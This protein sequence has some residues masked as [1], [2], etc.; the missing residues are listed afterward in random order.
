MGVV[1]GDITEVTFAHPLL[2]SGVFS[3]K[4]GETNTFDLG[5]FRN[6]DDAQGITGN[7]TLIIKKTRTRAS[8]EVVVAWDANLKEELGVLTKLAESNVETNWTITSSNK[9]VWGIKGIPVGDVQGDGSAATLT[10]KVAGGS[11][12]RLSSGL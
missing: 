2:G 3:P 4:A 5:G 10:L 9:T 6:D 11:M 1:G 12:K 7:G 8:F